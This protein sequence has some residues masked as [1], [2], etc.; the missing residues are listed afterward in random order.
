[1]VIIR[2]DTDP[3]VITQPAEISSAGTTVNDRFAQCLA[4]ATEAWNSSLDY[5]TVMKNQSYIVPWTA[6]DMAD[7]D[8][9]GIDGINPSAPS[10]I[11]VSEIPI[12]LP[13]FTEEKPVM[14]DIETSIGDPPDFIATE[15]I[16]NIP[17]LPDVAWPIF[18]KEAPLG[19]EI[20]ILVPDIPDLPNTPSP[21]SLV[22]PGP[23]DFTMP[24]F[25]GVEPVFTAEAPE[26]MFSWNE[27]MYNSDLLA[28]LEEKLSGDLVAGGSGLG[29]DVEQAIYD[30]AIARQAT[31]TEKMYN[32]ALNYF[33]SRGHSQPPGALAS[34][35]Q[36]IRN[37]ILQAETDLNNDILVQE[38]KL[39]QE[40]THFIIAQG[41][42]YEG[43]LMDHTNSLQQR[44]FDAAKYTVEYA[45]ILFD[46]KVK[47]Y[48]AQLEAYKTYF[49]V[50]EAKIRAEIAKAEFYRAQIE[51]VKVAAEIQMLNVEIYKAQITGINALVDLYNAQMNG[52][53]IKAQINKTKIDGYAV[54]VEAFKAK[55]EAL[56]ARYNAYQAQLAGETEKVKM[57]MAQAEAY[58]ARVRGYKSK[59]DVEIARVQIEVEKNKGEVQSFLAMVEKYKSDITAAI[60]AGELTAKEEELK[61]EI[62]KAD[63]QKY[64]VE[65][66]A[67]VKAY[68]GKI[69]EAKSQIEISL[70]E[71]E[72]QVQT[73]LAQYELN[74]RTTESGA[75]ILAQLSSSAMTAVSASAHIGYSEGRSDSRSWS[76]QE[77]ISDQFVKTYSHDVTKENVGRE[78]REV[79][80]YSETPSGGCG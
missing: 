79:H 20:V 2:S 25:E 46:V 66:D 27:V 61:V 73:L 38:S 60:A 40:N 19:D 72:I 13:V 52:A 18:T 80:S 74:N 41:I 42:A 17:D 48:M 62:F 31:K 43:K 28:A 23:P 56:V 35:I 78:C 63:T 7:I 24:S 12:T 32:E 55:N 51:G 68:L 50:F 11:T 70:K 34:D 44:A 9:A 45:V 29:A 33:S 58:D 1:M 53:A 77:S 4:F 59:A 30:R 75:K 54:E 64:A 69:E 67:I 49:A 6:I 10:G 16:L 8:P 21:S 26:P 47:L 5:I 76:G 39:A 71:A 65:I 15:P 36:V 37:I 22:V 57:Y 14:E 3:G